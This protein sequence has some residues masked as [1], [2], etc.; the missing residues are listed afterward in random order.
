MRNVIVSVIAF[1]LIL[2]GILFLC[3]VS[4]WYLLRSRIERN[5]W[6]NL[7]PC[8]ALTLLVYVIPV[9]GEMSFLALMTLLDYGAEHAREEVGGIIDVVIGP[10]RYMFDDSGS[11]G[12]GW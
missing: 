8:D 2:G 1:D 3:T 4:K 12:Q 5:E 6:K 9:F 7:N 11:A 10:M